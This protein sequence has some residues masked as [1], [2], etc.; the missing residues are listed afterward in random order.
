[1]SCSPGTFTSSFTQT[2]TQLFLDQVFAN[3]IGGF[4]PDANTPDPNWSRCLQCAAIDRARYKLQPVTPRSTFCSQCFQQYCFNPQNPP[5][6]SE[7][8][9]RKLTFVDP[10]PD[11]VT[12][13]D[14]FVTNDKYKLVGGLIGLA[15]FI[16]LMVYGLCVKLFPFHHHHL[17]HV[18]V[19]QDMVEEAEGG[20]N[21]IPGNF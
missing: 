12:Q 5:S 20:T 10:G 7:L 15:I 11:A 6:Q 17:A 21:T 4:I 9:N 13:L 2:F 16:G 14:D 19:F 18:C 8:P 1:M 3:T